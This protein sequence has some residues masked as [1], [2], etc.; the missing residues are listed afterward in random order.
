MTLVGL[1]PEAGYTTSSGGRI[2]AHEVDLCARAISSGD[3]HATIPGTSLGALNIAWGTPGTVV[4]VLAGASRRKLVEDTVTV[5][6]GHAAGA[7]S[8]TVRF[9]GERNCRRPVSVVMVRTAREIMR[10]QILVDEQ[11]LV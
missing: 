6:A 3:W 5:R 10:G 4:S 1:V 11:A 8:S 7:V 9:E 2:S